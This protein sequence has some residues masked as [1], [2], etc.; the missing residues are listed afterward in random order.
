MTGWLTHAPA[1]ASAEQLARLQA[2]CPVPLPAAYLDLLARFDGAEAGISVDPLW[3]VIYESAGV[4]AIA[5]DGALA[6]HLPGVFLFGGSGAGDG[7]AFET[8]GERAGRIVTFD[9]TVTD[10]AA[11]VRP[12]ADSF[13][14]LLALIDT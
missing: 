5:T 6:H 10:V 4:I 9:M 3:L 13:D 7:F 12:V 11:S 14:A 2:I 1:G 8:A